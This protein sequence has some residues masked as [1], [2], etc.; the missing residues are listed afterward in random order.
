M[1]FRWHFGW[2]ISYMYLN[3]V[4][5]FDQEQISMCFM[6]G[7]REFSLQY[8]KELNCLLL[9]KKCRIWSYW[10]KLIVHWFPTSFSGRTYVAIYLLRITTDGCEAIWNDWFTFLNK[11]FLLTKW[12]LAFLNILLSVFA[13]VRC[14]VLF[15][16]KFLLWQKSFHYC[17]YGIKNVFKPF[18]FSLY[19]VDCELGIKNKRSETIMNIY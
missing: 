9:N 1:E 15:M 8:C 2:W 16:A 7:I 6:L 5:N 3:I 12:K 11:L 4:I 19:T 14:T 17:M 18:K 13:Q 10:C